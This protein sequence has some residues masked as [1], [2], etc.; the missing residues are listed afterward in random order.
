MFRGL[1]PKFLFPNFYAMSATTELFLVGRIKLYVQ[2]W[3]CCSGS[4]V[5]FHACV[6][7]GAENTQSKVNM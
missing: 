4:E 1:S 3:W 5:N 2:I 6:A 7:A